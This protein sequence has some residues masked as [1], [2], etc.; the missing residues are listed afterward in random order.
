M[1]RSSSLE[2]CSALAT[3]HVIGIAADHGGYE[4]KNYL[5][6]MLRGAG[7][8]VVD[9]GDSLLEPDDDYPDFVIPLADAIANGKHSTGK[10]SPAKAV[11]NWKCITANC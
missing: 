8:V 7:A 11:M 6:K 2:M 3:S 1:T 9:F 5:T 4:L 10:H